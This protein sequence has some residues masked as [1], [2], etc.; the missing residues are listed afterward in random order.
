MAGKEQKLKAYILATETTCDLV[1]AVTATD[2]IPPSLASIAVSCG[3]G[4]MTDLEIGVNTKYRRKKSGCY[5]RAAYKL[6]KI[7]SVIWLMKE[8]GWLDS[9]EYEPLNKNVDNLSKMVWGLVK[10]V[11]RVGTEE[12]PPTKK[13]K[14]RGE[15]RK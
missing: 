11:N 14:K 6:S 8:T 9:E 5:A 12:K 13:T 2:L 3:V 1:H 4:V 7:N 15:K 10:A